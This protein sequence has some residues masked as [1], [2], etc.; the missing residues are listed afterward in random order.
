MRIGILVSGL[1]LLAVGYV[2]SK[3]GGNASDTPEGVTYLGVFIDSSTM[4]E[5]SIWGGIIFFLSILV[6]FVGAVV[7]VEPKKKEERQESKGK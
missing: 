2:L 6:I 3:L 7:A 1:V 5:L 4:W